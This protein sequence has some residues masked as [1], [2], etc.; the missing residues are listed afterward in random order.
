M[1]T[2]KNVGLNLVNNHTHQEFTMSKKQKTYNDQ[3]KAEV[4]KLIEHNDD[5]VSATAREL[6]I[7]MQTLSNWFN[8]PKAGKLAGT[9]QYDPNFIARIRRK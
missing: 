4:I 1:C 7:S 9:K 5:N 2:D 6:G 8:K 3:L